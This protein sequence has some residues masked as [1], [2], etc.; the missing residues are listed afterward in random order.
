MTTNDKAPT[1]P[2]NATTKTALRVLATFFDERSAA[3]HELAEQCRTEDESA[4]PEEKAVADMWHHAANTTWEL[5]GGRPDDA[6]NAYA[7]RKH[8]VNIS[9][10]ELGKLLD[11]LESVEEDRL[12]LEAIG[13]QNIE[14]KAHIFD[15][16]SRTSANECSNAERTQYEATIEQQRARIAELEAM[17]SASDS[18]LS[19]GESCWPRIA[20]RR[21][22]LIIRDLERGL[23][24]AES[25]ELYT[26]ERVRR[27]RSE[28]ASA[29][30]TLR[31]GTLDDIAEVLGSVVQSAAWAEQERELFG[32]GLAE[33]LET[34]VDDRRQALNEKLAAV[35]L[36]PNDWQQLSH[37]NAVS[38]RLF[39]T[40]FAMSELESPG[41]STRSTTPTPEESEASWKARLDDPSPAKRIFIGI[42]FERECPDGSR[43]HVDPSTVRL[44]LDGDA[45]LYQPIGRTDV[46]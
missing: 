16:E 42:T 25:V 10:K 46:E 6:T 28:L 24:T 39:V 22:H 13:S 8:F 7:L 23:T 9:A 15:L 27:A 1:V 18:L 17:R 30:L 31:M 40:H 4:Y 33:E 32:T 2:I 3:R 45:T 34:A 41:M 19:V 21:A 38:R 37:L 43:E 29:L 35:T 26:L 14:L 20:A 44:C 12:A 5:I 11:Q 36:E